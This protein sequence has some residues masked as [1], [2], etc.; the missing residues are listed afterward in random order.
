MMAHIFK[1]CSREAGLDTL[2]VPAQTRLQN[3]L[4]VKNKQ[5]KRKKMKVKLRDDVTAVR[6]SFIGL[7]VSPFSYSP[8]V[9][10]H[11]LLSFKKFFFF[12]TKTL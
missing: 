4:C 2:G 7:K 10:R 1:S 3:I 5:T 8:A 9:F 12:F 11:I 6:H